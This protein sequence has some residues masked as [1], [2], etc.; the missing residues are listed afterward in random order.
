LGY[1]S[2]EKPERAKFRGLI[3][4]I[5]VTNLH[6]VEGALPY[7]IVAGFDAEHGVENVLIE[8]LQYQGRPLLNAA[9][10]KCVIDDARDVNFK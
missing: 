5:R 9:D 1:T 3:R 2:E 10:A 8:G 6:V 4:D 7:S